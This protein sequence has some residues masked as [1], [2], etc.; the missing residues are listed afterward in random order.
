MGSL[1]R[2]AHGADPQRTGDDNALRADLRR[3]MDGRSEAPINLYGKYDLGLMRCR[4]TEKS[5]A[6]LLGHH[7]TF[8]AAKFGVV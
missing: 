1:P 6:L 4:G 8:F 2:F 3:L 5:R 7:A